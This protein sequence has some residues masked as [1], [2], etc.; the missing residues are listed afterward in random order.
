MLKEAKKMRD[1][2]QK[3]DDVTERR[4]LEQEAKKVED[5]AYRHARGLRG[6]KGQY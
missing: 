1:S 4:I 6:L 3:T 2:K 5:L